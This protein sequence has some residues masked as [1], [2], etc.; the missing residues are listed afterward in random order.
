MST[1]WADPV[2]FFFRAGRPDGNLCDGWCDASIREDGVRTDRDIV[3]IEDI[4]IT[5]YMAICAY[6]SINP[7]SGRKN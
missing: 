3:L 6:S 2:R 7:M 4:I 5:P 1:M